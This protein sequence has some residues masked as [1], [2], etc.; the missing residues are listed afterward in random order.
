MEELTA[1]LKARQLVKDVGI[2]SI[3]V[4]IAQFATAANATI[5]VRRDLNDAESG[6][7]FQ[8][9]GKNVIIVN[10][11]HREERQRFTVL[12]E[13]AHIVLN[14][15]SQH[16]G[17]HMSTSDLFSYRRRP[18]EEILCDV[19]AAECLLPSEHFKKDVEDIDVSLG[20]VKRLAERYKASLASTGSRFAVNANVPCAFVLMEHGTI[21]YVSTSIH[22]RELN[23]WIDFGVAAPKGSVANRL[24]GKTSFETEEYDEIEP[25]IW[26]NNGIGNYDLVAEESILLSEWDQCLSLIWVDEQIRSIGNSHSHDMDD[27]DEPLLEELDGFLPWPSKRKRR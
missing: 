14:L 2:V 13:I 15:P 12:H 10:G 26:F 24:F 7:T 11:N 6:Q 8:Y 4:D 19:F 1:I 25:D 22:L 5:K 27:D 9:G 17:D 21:R 16:H 18:K 3:P 20:E 23:G